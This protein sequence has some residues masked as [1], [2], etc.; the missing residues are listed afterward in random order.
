MSVKKKLGK[1]ENNATVSS[2]GNKN[3]TTK[4]EIYIKQKPFKTKV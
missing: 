2:K 3:I 4:L 1:I